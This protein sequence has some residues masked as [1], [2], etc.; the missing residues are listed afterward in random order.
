MNKHFGEPAIG[1]KWVYRNVKMQL[2]WRDEVDQHL[3]YRPNL[4]PNI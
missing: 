2:K 4:G 1:L 3:S